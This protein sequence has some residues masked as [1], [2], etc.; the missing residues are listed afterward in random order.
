MRSA[1]SIACFAAD[2][3]LVAFCCFSCS[4][5]SISACNACAAGVARSSSGRKSRSDIA[6]GSL[7]GGVPPP[8]DF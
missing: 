6:D 7:H 2:G 3:S 4:A 5:L 8:S 1:L